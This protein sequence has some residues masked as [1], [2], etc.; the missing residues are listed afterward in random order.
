[1]I[2]RDDPEQA[3]FILKNGQDGDSCC[4]QFEDLFSQADWNKPRGCCRFY[5]IGSQAPSGPT[6]IEKRRVSEDFFK[7][8]FRPCRDSS[9]QKIILKASGST[10]F[11]MSEKVWISAMSGTSDRRHCLAASW[12]ILRHRSALRCAFSAVSMGIERSEWKGGFHQHPVPW[13]SEL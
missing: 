13:L 2:L 8:S 10:A 12:A 7:S 4:F 1:M 6:I 3:D 9:S 5:F 11:S